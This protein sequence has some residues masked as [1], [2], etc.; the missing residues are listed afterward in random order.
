MII[1]HRSEDVT[2]TALRLVKD[3]KHLKGGTLSV[4]NR[5][6]AS[7]S[8]ASVFRPSHVVS[9]RVFRYTELECD[10]CSPRQVRDAVLLS[11][12]FEKA[13]AVQ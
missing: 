5:I 10:S 8:F 11:L 3:N 2:L 6:R 7:L 1:Y 12:D 4:V 9:G 13:S